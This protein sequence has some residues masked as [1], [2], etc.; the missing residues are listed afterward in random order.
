MHPSGIL[1]RFSYL[2]VHL[3]WVGRLN[4]S[5]LKESFGC[6]IS[7]FFTPLPIAQLKLAVLKQSWH[8]QIKP[9]HHTGV[10][11]TNERQNAHI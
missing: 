3:P 5:P 9:H 11:I 7:V 10:A 4:P 8:L 2:A 1:Y 6:I